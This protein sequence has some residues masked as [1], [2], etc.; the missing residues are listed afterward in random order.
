MD[1]KS[2]NSA[3]Y[4]LAKEALELADDQPAIFKLNNDCLEMIFSY[5]NLRDLIYV[6]KA[7]PRFRTIADY[8]Y[9][10]QKDLEIEIFD[11]TFQEMS[12]LSKRVGS[13]TCKLT[14]FGMGVYDYG[15][16]QEFKKLQIFKLQRNPTSHNFRDY[17]LMYL[18]S[19]QTLEHVEIVNT[20]VTN[21]GIIE[22]VKDC[23]N[24]K[25]LDIQKCIEINKELILRLLPIL[26]ERS[27]DLEICVFGT[28]INRSVEEEL[29]LTGN[30][31]IRLNWQ[32]IY[33][34]SSSSLSSVSQRS[35]LSWHPFDSSDFDQVDSSDSKE[36]SSSS[37][38]DDLSESNQN[39]FQ[40]LDQHDS[41][42]SDQDDSLDSDPIDFQKLD[43]EEYLEPN[44]EENSDPDHG[45]YLEP[46]QDDYSD[47]DHGE[48]FE[49]DQE[50]YLEPNL[51]DYSDP[52]HGDF[53]EPNQEDY[54]EPNQEDYSDPDHGVYLEPNQE[55]YLEPNQEDYLEPNQEDYAD[56]DHGEYF[57]QDQDYYLELNEDDFLDPD[58]GDY[59]EPDQDYFE[60]DQSDSYDSDYY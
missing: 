2:E 24:L 58:H 47:P 40:D 17:Q 5:L 18:K 39:D 56:P 50:D 30:E 32:F 27:H 55:D 43:L 23:P 22:F 6:E 26:N 29:Q 54:L 49:Q 34:E 45:D 21:N 44:H 19:R 57:E 14:L 28:G 35:D 46:N 9:K 51:D 59:F 60:P 33:L 41:S 7:C 11:F 52:D 53:L 1:N 42:E 12:E 36:D 13:I 15:F 48:Y 38:Q 20:S 31:R 4:N 16:L 25:V 3:E 37:D 10:K 8:F